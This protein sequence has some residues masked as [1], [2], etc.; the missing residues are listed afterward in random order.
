[1]TKSPEM[2]ILHFHICVELRGNYYYLF[3]LPMGFYTVAV[4]LQ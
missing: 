1:M 2:I 3:K 4:V